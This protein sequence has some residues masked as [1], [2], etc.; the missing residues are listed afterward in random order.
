MDGPGH[1]DPLRRVRSKITRS[2]IQKLAADA[3]T[4]AIA[5]A[6]T[7]GSPVSVMMSDVTAT[8]VSTEIAPV[9][10]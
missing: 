1:T 3:A 4:T 7:I 9:V 8:L 10:R 2:L 6:G 5:L